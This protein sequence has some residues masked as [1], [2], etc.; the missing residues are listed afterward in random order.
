MT[1]TYSRVEL[2]IYFNQT[3]EINRQRQFIWFETY[4]YRNKQ[5]FIFRDTLDCFSVFDR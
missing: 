1:S 4:L 5:Y 3:A 2:S